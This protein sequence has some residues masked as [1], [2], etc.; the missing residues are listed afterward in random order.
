[1]DD[2][3]QNTTLNHVKIQNCY[4]LKLIFRISAHGSFFLLYPPLPESLYTLSISIFVLPEM[5][6]MHLNLFV[7][8][9]TRNCCC[10]EDKLV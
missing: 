10:R 5:P 4:Y 3:S 8:G 6:E 2:T 7:L 9:K 1:M